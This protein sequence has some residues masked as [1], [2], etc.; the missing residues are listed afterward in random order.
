PC[1]SS[2]SAYASEVALRFA[3]ARLYVGGMACIVSQSLPKPRD[4]LVYDVV[5]YDDV[6]PGTRHQFLDRDELRGAI[7]EMKQDGVR[8]GIENDRM[9]SA[10]EAPRADI[11]GP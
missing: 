2:R 3:R 1:R 5:S 10:A 4:R 7:K 6:A 8:L 11:Q 9:G